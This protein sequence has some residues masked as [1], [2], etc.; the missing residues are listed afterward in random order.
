MDPWPRVL[1]E[2]EEMGERRV[3]GERYGIVAGGRLVEVADVVVQ[4]VAVPVVEALD[5]LLVRDDVSEVIIDRAA[6]D[7]II[8]EDAV[9]LRA[10]S[11][12]LHAIRQRRMPSGN[13]MISARITLS[14]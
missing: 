11:H 4:R 5:V 13:A 9:H 14:A 6:E 7:R 3:A 2:R 10:R 8:N 1:R 12:V